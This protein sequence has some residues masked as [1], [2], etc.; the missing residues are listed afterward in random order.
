MKKKFIIIAGILL[1]ISFC[2]V[3]PANAFTINSPNGG[4][5]WQAGY[6]SPRSA[7]I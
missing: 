3:L 7:G 4:E 6:C 1:L 2:F 5:N